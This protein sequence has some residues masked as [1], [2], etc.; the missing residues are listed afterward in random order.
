M[1][2]A[3]TICFV[4]SECVKCTTRM[5]LRMEVTILT[6]IDGAPDMR[7]EAIASPKKCT[8]RRPCEWLM[9]FLFLREIFFSLRP[10]PNFFS[11]RS[12][13]LAE[14]FRGGVSRTRY[15][16]VKISARNI[17]STKIYPK[18]WVSAFPKS[19]CYL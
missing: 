15:L 12:S 19:L 13:N 11:L 3:L 9:L 7:A 1:D 14:I 10:H 6:A 16:T 5:Y 2:G 18:M 4:K 8:L 17:E